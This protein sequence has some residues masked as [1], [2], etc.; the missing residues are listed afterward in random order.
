MRLVGRTKSPFPQMSQTTLEDV[1][2]RLL[3]VSVKPFRSLLEEDMAC[4]VVH[5][6][7]MYLCRLR[8]KLGSNEKVI[9]Y[10]ESRKC[11]PDPSSA[12][13][14]SLPIHTLLPPSSQ[15][16]FNGICPLPMRVDLLTGGETIFPGFAGESDMS[17][18][19]IDLA[20]LNT[21]M[22][23]ISRTTPPTPELVLKKFRIK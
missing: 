2:T 5:Q 3:A 1:K 23:D 17:M 4:S 11:T 22:R 21:G 14:N 19:P 18:E 9:E 13:V 10:V 16:Q 6:R 12:W 8:D 7:Y 20:P 15:S